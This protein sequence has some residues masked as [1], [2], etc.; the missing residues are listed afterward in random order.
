MNFLSL[1]S[2]TVYSCLTHS[3]GRNR[4]ERRTSKRFAGAVLIS[5]AIF[6]FIFH[7]LY[8]IF[9]QFLSFLEQTT[10]PEN[11]QIGLWNKVQI[12]CVISSVLHRILPSC[13]T[14]PNAPI[15]HSVGVLQS[16]SATGSSGRSHRLTGITESV[17]VRIRHWAKGTGR[18]ERAEW[19]HL[20]TGPRRASNQKTRRHPGE[21]GTSRPPR[22][23]K[24]QQES[25]R[26]NQTW[27]VR[28]CL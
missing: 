8:L 2:L 3:L 12:R 9:L 25:A 14:I 26:S 11:T 6:I 4:K 1:F 20:W 17:Y 21:E 23:A 19:L 28:R 13:F 5:F 22:G 16:V 24:W 15:L 18:T 27:Q 7:I 10:S